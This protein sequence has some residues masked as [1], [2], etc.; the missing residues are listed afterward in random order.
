MKSSRTACHPERLAAF[1][2]EGLPDEQLQVLEEHLSTCELCQSR[3]E[4][5]ISSRQV[6]PMLEHLRGQVSS[7][8][9]PPND[10]LRQA[11]DRSQN[12]LGIREFAAR[13]FPIGSDHPVANPPADSH[14]GTTV[15]PNG[16]SLFDA[17]QSNEQ[18]LGAI[19]HFDLL[20]PLGSGGMGF[21]YKAYDRRLQRLVAVK[22]LSPTMA[23]TGA[24]RQ[25]FLREAQAAATIV[26]PHVVPIHSIGTI[27]GLPYLVMSYVDGTDLQHW[28]HDNG[29]MAIVDSLRI[30]QQI[31]AGL[32]AAH[33]QGI[34]HRDVKP[35]NV[36]IRPAILQA[37][38]TD[39]GLAMVADEASLTNS[40]LTPGTPSFMSP[41]QARG[42]TIDARSDWYSLGCVL[43]TML[44]GH[45]PYRGPHAVAILTRMLS[46]EP[47][48][49]SHYRPEIPPWLDR[50][51]LLLLHRDADRRLADGE[52]VQRLFA[53]CIRH[54]ENPSRYALP[55]DLMPRKLAFRPVGYAM[56]GIIALI[57]LMMIWRVYQPAVWP[58]TAKVPAV[59]SSMTAETLHQHNG[60]SHG[61]TIESMSDT[62]IDP[63]DSNPTSV[64]SPDV[65]F[66]ETIL[67]RQQFLSEERATN[68]LLQ[69]LD[70]ELRAL[71]IEY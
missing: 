63:A 17:P 21:V 28:I 37:S 69:Q 30:G 4:E 23:S 52:N 39:F 22:V 59:S 43:Y 14:R 9:I 58:G 18:L 70:E 16:T 29:K 10:P 49:P 25:R 68:R 64:D 12:Q 6:L 15:P 36:L 40:G 51:V 57:S 47:K 32:L 46:E 71:E 5:Q 26:S 11:D 34:V 35:G 42:E 67:L 13:W 53:D 19:D 41:E 20:Q 56:A 7:V 33:Q 3:F 61:P 66:A 1:W 38:I 62:E 44:V 55:G 50:L 27:G 2:S 54:L 60:F 24:A 31:S 8:S 45:P 65:I 48:P